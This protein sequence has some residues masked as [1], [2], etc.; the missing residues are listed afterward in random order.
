MKEIV[1]DGV[2]YMLIPKS[3]GYGWRLPTIMELKSL[4]NYSK[5]SPACDLKDT[6]NEYYWSSTAH[7]KYAAV[8]WV[9]HFTSGYDDTHDKSHDNFVRCVRETEDCKLEWSKSSDKAM[10]YSEALEWCK[11]LTIED[12]YKG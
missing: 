6:R 1:V 3:K 8:A 5:Y 2:E 12:V 11:T 4:V 10:T 9:I 7:V